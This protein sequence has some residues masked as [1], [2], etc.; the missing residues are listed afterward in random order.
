[1]ADEN[2]DGSKVV[3]PNLRDLR[4][5]SPQEKSEFASKGGKASGKVRKL[6]GT[7]Q[8]IAKEI[9]NG[10]S[11]NKVKANIAKYFPEIAE[12]DDLNIKTAMVYIQ[13]AKALAGDTKAFEIMRDTAGEKP[14]DVHKLEDPV[15]VKK[16]FISAEEKAA[17]DSHIEEALRDGN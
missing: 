8:K 15:I 1:M 11:P 16:V 10:S 3:Y 7:F 5:L 17:V 4:A 12:D 2:K 13:A 6:K 14:V 9:L